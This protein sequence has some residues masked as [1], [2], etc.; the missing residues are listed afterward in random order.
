MEKTKFKTCGLHF[1]SLYIYQM[2]EQNKHTWRIY[3]SLLRKNETEV[4]N[5]ELG[6]KWFLKTHLTWRNLLA[7]N[8]PQRWQRSR[9]KKYKCIGTGCAS[10]KCLHAPRGQSS[11]VL[12]VHRGFL[13]PSDIKTNSNWMIKNILLNNNGF[14]CFRW[15]NN[16][17]Q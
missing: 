1:L 3:F 9:E 10:E 8:L 5:R 6:R 2:S 15:V 11:S 12:R 4:E 13:H 7:L 14:Q 17:R 16:K